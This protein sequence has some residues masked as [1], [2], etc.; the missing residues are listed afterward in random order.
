VY[1]IRSYI[2]PKTNKLV[3]YKLSF[4]TN[5]KIAKNLNK[6]HG[7]NINSQT[8]ISSRKQFIILNSK[9]KK[10]KNGIN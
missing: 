6:I 1:D 10:D 2:C 8:K 4:S 3:P 7:P 5:N 9:P